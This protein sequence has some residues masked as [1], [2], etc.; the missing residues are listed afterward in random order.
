MIQIFCHFVSEVSSVCSFSFLREGRWAGGR[1]CTVIFLFWSCCYIWCKKCVWG[2][3]FAQWSIDFAE[4]HKLYEMISF[5]TIFS[6]SVLFQ[7]TRVFQYRGLAAVPGIS[8]ASASQ[9]VNHFW[10]IQILIGPQFLNNNVLIW[11]QPTSLAE[12]LAVV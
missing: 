9:V 10:I 4:V 8:Q 11:C 2:W 5:L 7:D 12:T 3:I 6:K 1:L